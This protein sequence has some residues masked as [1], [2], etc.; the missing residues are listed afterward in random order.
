MDGVFN[1][2][3]SLILI[4]C[5]LVGSLKFS[6]ISCIVYLNKINDYYNLH[7]KYQ[8]YMDVVPISL[9]ISLPISLHCCLPVWTAFSWLR[10]R[11][12]E[13]LFCH[14]VSWQLIEG[15]GLLCLSPRLAGTLLSLCLFLFLVTLPLSQPCL[16]VI[17]KETLLLWR[18]TSST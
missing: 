13:Y 2:L 12:V 9:R 7:V 4:L 8:W 10:E 1:W 6:V 5:W 15:H 16:S 17:L 18:F 11:L 14:W 3:V